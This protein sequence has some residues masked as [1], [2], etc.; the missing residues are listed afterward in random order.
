MGSSSDAEI[1]DTIPEAPQPS[2]TIVL[3]RKELLHRLST[4]ISSIDWLSTYICSLDDRS[5]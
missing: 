1:I 4:Y 2:A 5:V 3:D